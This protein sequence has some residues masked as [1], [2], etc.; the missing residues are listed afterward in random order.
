MCLAIVGKIVKLEKGQTAIVD[1]GGV[2][3]R[4]SVAL[5]DEKQL[6][7]NSY[8]LVHAGFAI[9]TL[10]EKEAEKIIEAWKEVGL[11]RAYERD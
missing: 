8:V 4:I 10:D 7:E 1:F 3:R 2:K 11:Q 9:Q 6:K 5:L